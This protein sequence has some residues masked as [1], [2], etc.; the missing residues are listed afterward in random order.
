MVDSISSAVTTTTAALTA[1]TSSSL[2]A[3]QPG[4]SVATSNSVISASDRSEF[5][6]FYT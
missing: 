3:I 2:T 5:V 1:T 4:S 6:Y